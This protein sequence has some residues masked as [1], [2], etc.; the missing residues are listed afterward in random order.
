MRNIQEIAFEI[1]LEA[2]CAKFACCLFYKVS[3]TARADRDIII[4]QGQLRGTAIREKISFQQGNYLRL[5]PS[6]EDIKR[7][8]VFPFF[9]YPG[10]DL[11]FDYI[12]VRASPPLQL[13]LCYAALGM[14]ILYCKK[15]C[16]DWLAVGYVNGWAIQYDDNVSS[17]APF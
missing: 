9:R 3:D 15:Q 8:E 6:S 4:V 10:R 14:N 1:F 11:C 13:Y 17:F 7:A 2:Q 12:S 5:K 16:W